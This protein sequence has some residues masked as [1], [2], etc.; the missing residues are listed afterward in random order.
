MRER[1]WGWREEENDSEIEEEAMDLG[2]LRIGEGG[3]NCEVGFRSGGEQMTS[4]SLLP[5]PQARLRFD[6]V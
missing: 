3:S 1:G 5:Y 2:N 4:L 6:E